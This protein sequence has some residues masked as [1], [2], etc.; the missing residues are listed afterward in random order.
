MQKSAYKLQWTAVGRRSILPRSG[1][2][3]GIPG[4]RIHGHAHACKEK[5]RVIYARWSYEVNALVLLALS[6]ISVQTKRTAK[7]MRTTDVVTVHY[8]FGCHPAERSST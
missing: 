6:N 7:R 1:A 2:V 3:T 4:R 5:V 8:R